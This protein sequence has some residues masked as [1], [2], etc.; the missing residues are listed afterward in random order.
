MKF[1]SPKRS[2][3]RNAKRFR[4][5]RRS[6]VRRDKLRKEY[7]HKEQHNGTDERRTEEAA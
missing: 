4:G 3:S 6:N 2:I 5:D 7:N 1:K